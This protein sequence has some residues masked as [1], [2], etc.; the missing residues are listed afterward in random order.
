MAQ[1]W[2]IFTCINNCISDSQSSQNYHIF[3]GRMKLYMLGP[4][5]KGESNIEKSV[6][7]A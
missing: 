6:Q 4:D 1:V 7:S 2:L 3:T 5:T